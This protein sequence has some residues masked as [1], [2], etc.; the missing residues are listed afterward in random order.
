MAPHGKPVSIQLRSH[1]PSVHKAG[2]SSSQRLALL[3][4]MR[5]A[6]HTASAG[7]SASQAGSSKVMAPAIGAGM[8][9]MSC[10]L[11]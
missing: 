1:S 4:P 11:M 8:P 2:N 9:P 3:V 7:N 5:Q 10:R 6:S